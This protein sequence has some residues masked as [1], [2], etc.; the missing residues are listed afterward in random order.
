MH[1]EIWQ[2]IIEIISGEKINIHMRTL[3]KNVK[4]VTKASVID[5]GYCT[6]SNGIIDYVGTEE[7]QADQVLDG[8]GNYLLPGFIDVHCH[9]AKGFEFIDANVEQIQEICKFHLNNGTTTLLATTLTASQKQTEMAL[10]NIEKYIRNNL[11]GNLIGVHLEGPCLNSKQSGAQ[12]TKF[13]RLPKELNL[14]DLKRKYPFIYKVSVAPELDGGMKIGEQ[15]EKLGIIMSIAHTEADFKTVQKAVKNGYKSITHLYSGMNGVT[16]KNL[17]RVA[18]AVEAGLYLDDICVEIIADGKHLPNELLK[19]IYKIKGADKICLITDATR[20]TGLNDGTISRIGCAENSLSI[21]VEDGV[22]KL[23]DRSSFAGS[24]ATFDK[25][26]KTMLGAVDGN[27]VEL[28]KMCSTTPAREL[29][30]TDRG[31]ISVGKRAD[32]L[33][34]N[35]CAEIE[36]IYI[37]GKNIK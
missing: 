15:G 33:L 36:K 1:I 6:F 7:I 34:I 17:F 21:I 20:A 24:V 3:I 4:I 14:V 10:Q 9:G 12:D 16:R 2:V 22:A 25:L 30:L 19:F 32:V 8:K 29:N 18:G 28:A 26:Y 23:L 31:E 27:V 5:N 13:M 11:E 35:N 37:K